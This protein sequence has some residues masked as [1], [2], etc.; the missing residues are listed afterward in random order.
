MGETTKNFHDHKKALSQ[1]KPYQ[2]LVRNTW[3]V[4]KDFL[5]NPHKYLSRMPWKYDEFL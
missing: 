2:Q 5:F 4:N 1:V 3:E